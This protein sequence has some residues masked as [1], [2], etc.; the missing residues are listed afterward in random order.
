MFN[1][2]KVWSYKMKKQ[3]KDKIS[4]FELPDI[5]K[6]KP[7]FI[8]LKNNLEKT[9][10][11]EI[12]SEVLQKQI[13]KDFTEKEK[14]DVEPHYVASHKSKIWTWHRNFKNFG[15]LCDSR[16]SSVKDFEQSLEM[17]KWFLIESTESWK[18]YF[19][20]AFAENK[21]FPY[22]CLNITDKEYG[23]ASWIYILLYNKIKYYQQMYWEDRTLEEL[24]QNEEFKKF[25]KLSKKDWILKLETDDTEI[26]KEANKYNWSWYKEYKDL[27]SKE[28]KLEDC[29]ILDQQNYDFLEKLFKDLS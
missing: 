16:M 22:T 5:I 28:K 20:K 29:E 2:L 7:F 11:K 24:N 27:I 21:L 25:G 26:F 23:W 15:W 9:L 3:L 13:S 19:I 18:E 4:S 10:T 12:S 17:K 6:D 14:L 8:K 1:G